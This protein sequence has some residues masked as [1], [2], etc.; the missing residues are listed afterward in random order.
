MLYTYIVGDK[1]SKP[2]LNRLCQVCK[3]CFILF[4]RSVRRDINSPCNRSIPHLRQLSNRWT[5]NVRS[6]S[7]GYR[8][9]RPAWHFRYLLYRRTCI[10]DVRTHEFPFHFSVTSEFPSN[11]NIK[12]R[13]CIVS[14]QRDLSHYSESISFEREMRARR[15]NRLE[16]PPVIHEASLTH[17]SILRACLEFFASRISS[18]LP[19]YSRT[20]FLSFMLLCVLMSSLMN[21]TILIICQE[22]EDGYRRVSRN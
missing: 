9:T 14:P 17:N 5:V 18:N 11:V 13:L 4:D 2:L 6:G 7:R 16:D 22:L 15:T 20:F 8:I 12:T 19:R 21:R 10:N 3:S 1:I